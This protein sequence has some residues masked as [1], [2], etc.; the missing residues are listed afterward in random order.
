MIYDTLL[1]TRKASYE[2]LAKCNNYLKYLMQGQFKVQMYGF[3]GHANAQFLN[4]SL[5]SF[6]QIANTHQN[7]DGFSQKY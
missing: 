2:F 3:A 5:Q 7:F 1:D 4:N 6:F